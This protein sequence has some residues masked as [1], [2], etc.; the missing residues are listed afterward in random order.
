[1]YTVYCFKA[2]LSIK[3]KNLSRDVSWA[4][5]PG[6]LVVAKGARLPPGLQRGEQWRLRPPRLLSAVQNVLSGWDQAGGGDSRAGVIWEI[7]FLKSDRV[8]RLTCLRGGE[9]AVVAS[10]AHSQMQGRRVFVPSSEHPLSPYVPD[11]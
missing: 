10:S 3:V 7:L 5:P 4:R 9:W 11:A 1:M 8:G 6:P 2:N